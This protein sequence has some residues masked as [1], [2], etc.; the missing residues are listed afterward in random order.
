MNKKKESSIII[1]LLLIPLGWI[2]LQGYHLVIQK[3]IVLYLISK[4]P[5]L[6]ESF[7]MPY[8]FVASMLNLIIFGTLAVIWP[9]QG[10][11]YEWKPN[12][13]QGLVV[14]GL[15]LVSIAYPILVTT[16]GS[17]NP[18]KKAG[19]VIWTITPIQEEIIFRGFLYCFLLGIFKKSDVSTLKEI[20]P[21]ILIGSILFSLWHLSPHAI[22]KYGWYFM[23]GQ[24]MLTFTV[25]I[26]FNLLRFWTKSIWLVIPVHAA[27]NFMLSIF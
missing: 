16:F 24:L 9:R 8:P 13:T 14:L 10:L 18:F 26:I 11:G 22:N 6:S 3:P 21:V 19:F 25:G 7:T 12:R 23:A 17:V 4:F 15:I 2:V 5:K 1:F 27:G 20:I